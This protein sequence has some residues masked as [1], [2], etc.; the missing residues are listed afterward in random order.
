MYSLLDVVTLAGAGR[1]EA[2]TALRRAAAEL[3]GLRGAL[4]APTL[5]GAYNGGDLIVR[6]TFDDEDA[7]GRAA[8]SAA[9]RA[10]EAFLADRARVARI[11][12]AGFQAGAAGGTTGAGRIYRVA[13]FCANV[14][15]TPERL[16]AFARHT[17]AMGDHIGAMGRW[18]LSRPAEAAGTRNWTHVWEKEYADLSGLLGAYMMHPV[19]WAHVE[20]WFDP[21]YPEWLVDTQLV[22]TF[23]AIDEPVILG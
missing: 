16:E 4:I 12:H 2:A 19:H 5:D 3:P 22:H 1:D 10:I 11:D 18:Q 7:A 17:A 14:N 13:L 23:C 8:A 20:R 9:G 21:E 15:P 6:L